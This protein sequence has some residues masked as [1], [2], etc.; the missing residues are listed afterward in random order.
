MV[1]K[2]FKTELGKVYGRLTVV[3]PDGVSESGHAMW[4]ARCECNNV[5]SV[6]GVDLRSGHVRSCGCLRNE[7]CA[8]I[9]D[10]GRRERRRRA[11]LIHAL[12]TT[13]LYPKGKP[14]E[15]RK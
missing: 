2:T 9:G 14:K 4:L 11:E 13:G 7:H 12:F 3:A 15:L 8:K 1:W 5:V 10:A 6:A